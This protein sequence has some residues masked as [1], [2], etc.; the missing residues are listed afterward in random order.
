MRKLKFIKSADGSRIV[1]LRSI[2]AVR[3][4]EHNGNGFKAS[5]VVATLKGGADPI[6]L[7][8]YTA[9]D[10][11]TEAENM[12]STARADMDRLLSLLNGARLRRGEEW[13]SSAKGE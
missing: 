8:A 13:P 1:R 6:T 11:T 2:K 3:L 9:L 7:A 10:G 12:P 5:K 4:V